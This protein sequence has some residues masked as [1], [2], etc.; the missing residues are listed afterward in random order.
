MDNVPNPSSE[1][2]RPNAHDY[3]Q[4]EEI[5]RHTDNA[6]TSSRVA[7]ETPAALK[8]IDATDPAQEGQQTRKFGPEEEPFVLQVKV[9]KEE[10]QQQQKQLQQRLQ[11]S[12]PQQEQPQQEQAQP[13]HE[14]PQ[15]QQEKPQP[16]RKH[17]QQQR[18][19]RD[20]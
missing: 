4:L 20:R 18:E 8:D 15:S 14:Q 19:Q 3:E 1:D 12:Q 2:M 5:Y 11:Q 9:V 6:N 17:L 7:N 16:Q 10:D 13:H